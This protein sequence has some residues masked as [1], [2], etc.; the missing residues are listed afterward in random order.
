MNNKIQSSDS[1]L[2]QP[3]RARAAAYLLHLIHIEYLRSLVARGSFFAESCQ[4][5][6][7]VSLRAASVSAQFSVALAAANASR[8]LHACQLKLHL[9]QTFFKH[10]KLS[11]AAGSHTIA[12]TTASHTLANRTLS[13]PKASLAPS[14]EDRFGYRLQ[15]S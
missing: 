2:K 3:F 1:A 14:I 12:T 11:E 4:S 13:A 7:F 6:R 10:L 15:V 5:A 9:L 8:Y